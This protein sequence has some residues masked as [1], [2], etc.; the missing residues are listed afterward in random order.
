MPQQ[1]RLAGLVAWSSVLA[2]LLLTSACVRVSATRLAPSGEPRVPRDSVHVF[3][4]TSP[5]EYTEVAVLRA[6]RFA[7][8][9]A[10]VLRAL[11]DRASQLGANG[12]LLL[13]ARGAVASSGSGTHVVIGGR[14]DGSVIVGQTHSEVDEFERAVAI[15]WNARKPASTTSARDSGA[16]AATPR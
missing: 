8:S 11:R 13:N 4:T 12:L 14:A 10:K 9:D 2:G 3:V 15:R 16:S 1:R 7:V 5:A 6:K